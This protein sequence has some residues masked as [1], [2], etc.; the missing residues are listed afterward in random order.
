MAFFI[1]GLIRQDHDTLAGGTTQGRLRSLAGKH[2]F[3]WS[4]LRLPVEKDFCLACLSLS[5][6]EGTPSLALGLGRAA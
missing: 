1:G 5:A 6:S 3:T 4:K 2:Q